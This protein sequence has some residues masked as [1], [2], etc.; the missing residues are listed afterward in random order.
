MTT[1]LH[2]I[3]RDFIAGLSAG[4]LPMD[5]CAEDMTVWTTTSGDGAL[6]SREKYAGGLKM[7]AG[8]FDG[9][10]AYSIDALIAEKDRVAIEARSAGTLVNG[11]AFGNRY[12]FLLT[13]RDGRI[14][15]VAEHFNPEPVRTQIAP[16]IQAA[17]AKAAG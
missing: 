5:L 6:A 4:I 14:A 16:L 12:V 2:Q 8:F 3:A 10:L 11:D 15:S 1:D 13:V 17:M 9:G 7:L